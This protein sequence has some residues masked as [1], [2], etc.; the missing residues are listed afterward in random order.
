MNTLSLTVYDYSEWSLIPRVTKSPEHT[1]LICVAWPYMN[2][3]LHIGHL[4]GYLLPADCIARVFRLCGYRTLMV[5]GSDCYG[6]PIL[7]TALKE[8]S[9]PDQI[10]SYYHSEALKL[11]KLLEMSFDNYSATVNSTHHQ[12]VKDMFLKILRNG[13]IFS[14]KDLQFYSPSLKKFLPDRFVVGD[15]PKC[16]AKGIKSDQCENCSAVLAPQD[17]CNPRSI[18]D[19]RNV[20]L[21]ETEHYFFNWPKIQDSL[22]SYVNAHSELWRTWVLSETKKWLR[23]GLKPR[24][25]TRDLDWGVELPKDSLS[26]AEKIP[27]LQSKRIYVWFEAV[28]GYLSST[29]EY[30]LRKSLNLN[31]FWR[32]P[33]SKHYYFMGKD[34][35]PFHTLF[36]PGQLMAADKSYNLPYFPAINQYLLLGEDKF[37]KSA[38]RIID[39]Y[40]FL[41][42]YGVDRSRFYF[43]TFAPETSDS[44]FSIEHFKEQV[45]S[46][47]VGKIGNYLSRVLKLAGRGFT[48]EVSNHVFESFMPFLDRYLGF[49][50]KAS[51]RGMCQTALDYADFLNKKF[52]DTQ[53][54]SLDKNSTEFIRKMSDFVS[55]ALLLIN[56]LKPVIPK[57]SSEAEHM[58]GIQE[59]DYL[60]VNV[61][62]FQKAVSGIKIQ[63]VHNLFERVN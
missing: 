23:E 38:G 1:V 61:D 11:F 29:V 17:I 51:S 43:L 8:N 54:W 63:D 10:V 35:L 33:K 5:S 60:V 45:N 20:E 56:L 19:N 27:D 4:A 13:Y 30:C 36:W 3:R 39:S 7:V 55:S 62:S 16:G 18:I 58:L 6:T 40:E 37:S 32:N 31:L 42:N 57:A 48:P 41:S 12:T 52:S 14:Q 34:N 44:S 15:C 9:T 22:E 59:I 25:I 53:P 26:D 46:L 47:L 2:G 24:A 49:V 28:T 21:R 50:E